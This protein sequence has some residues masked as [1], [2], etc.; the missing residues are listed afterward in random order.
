V[1]N[2]ARRRSLRILLLSGLMLCCFAARADALTVVPPAPVGTSLHPGDE[3]VIS[4]SDKAAGTTLKIWDGG[5]YDFCDGLPAAGDAGAWSCS[6]NGPFGPG[7]YDYA[8]RVF[9]ASDNQIG[10]DI[11]VSFTVVSRL[12]VNAAS[13]R[14]TSGKTLTITG[15]ADGGEAVHAFVSSQAD[16]SLQLPLTCSVDDS[17]NTFSCT[18]TSGTSGRRSR[19]AALPVGA[20]LLHVT[21]VDSELGQIAEL[22]QDITVGPPVA[23]PPTH[24]ATPTPAPTPT[25]SPSPTTAP[26]PT[27]SPTLS[28]SPSGTPSATPTVVEPAPATGTPVAPVTEAAPPIEPISN[29]LRPTAPSP[30]LS[31]LIGL[32]IVGFVTIT[33]SGGAAFSR[34]RL[35]PV[36]PVILS[37]GSDDEDLDRETDHRSDLGWGDRSWTW[38]FP[39]HVV[40]DRLG[41]KDSHTIAP[42]SPLV[43]RLLADAGY[44]RSILG[45]AWLLPTIAAVALAGMALADVHGRPLPPAVGLVAAIIVLACVD[46]IAGAI[47][48]GVFW[49]GVIVSGGLGDAAR[50]DAAGSIGVLLV[51]G[52]LW[53]GLPLIGSAARPFRRRWSRRR[54]AAAESSYGW[55]RLADAFI[56]AALCGWISYKLTT[57]LPAF[58]GFKLEIAQHAL[59][60]GIATAAGVAL[61]IL[62]EEV[63]EHGYPQRLHEVETPGSLPDPSIVVDIGGALFRSGLVTLIAYVFLHDCWQLWVGAALVGIIEVG[64]VFKARLPQSQQL[65]RALPRGITEILVMLIVC[66]V[67]ARLA[68]TKPVDLTELR[69]AFVIMA[70]PSFAVSLAGLFAKDVEPLPWRW[71]R[72]LA[73]AAVYVAIVLTVVYGW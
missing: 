16:S 67:V 8:V 62:L 5:A 56:A 33:A 66:T 11:P 57:A 71:R 19:A 3:V 73:G 6:L 24:T 10:A 50:P 30:D 23:T 26:T 4:G 60:V 69:N 53:T 47:A 35:M 27:A 58:V 38:R 68:A 52:L 61:R 1:R 49:V 32:L 44:L 12:H 72:Q 51:L 59:T 48:S 39:G 29:P 65:G 41:R 21:E 45:I 55:D 7:T 43:G 18:D 64:T 70:V 63:A 28:A 22:Q 13:L 54:R 40:A 20:Y 31:V 42:R 46:A 37:S 2:H 14:A 34:L 25:A 36:M 15:Q 9:D 17:A